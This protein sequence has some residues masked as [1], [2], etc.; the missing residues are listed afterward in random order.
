MSV[1]NVG[2]GL[3]TQWIG[4]T[5]DVLMADK[6]AEGQPKVLDIVPEAINTALQLA[7]LPALPPAHSDLAMLGLEALLTLVSNSS[8]E[9]KLEA[10]K[11]GVEKGAPLLAQAVGLQMEALAGDDVVLQLGAAML[12]WAGDNPVAIFNLGAQIATTVAAGIAS[13]G[14]SLPGDLLKLAPTLMSAAAGV[15]QEAGITPGAI[16]GYVTTGFLQ[17]IGVPEAN[18][19]QIGQV[20]AALADVSTDVMLAISTNGKHPLDA[21]KLAKAASAIA[22]AVGV[23]PDAAAIVAAVAVQGLML[24]TN[25]TGFLL[26]GNSAGDYGGIG[27]LASKTWELASKSFESLLKG[28]GLQHLPDLL[29]ALQDLEP[30]VKTLVD[31]VGKDM[32]SVDAATNESVWTA[33][34]DQLEK[35]LKISLD[36]FMP[37]IPTLA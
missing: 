37:V 17:M 12:K 25:V 35:L 14:T 3:G 27:D 24:G 11:K 26:A 34:N 10:I 15:L 30:M 16:A 31:Q 28:E 21:D 8:Q 23:K 33:V 6:N 29:T 1:N 32:G 7:G 9:A 20:T 2:S 18:A 4:K 36:D 19:E 5:A 13:G 22:Q